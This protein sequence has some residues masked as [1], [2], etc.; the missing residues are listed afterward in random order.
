[1]LVAE[2]ERGMLVLALARLLRRYRSELAPPAIAA[3][4]ALTAAWTHARHSG[5]AIPVAALSVALSATLGAP[6]DRWPLGRYLAR[7]R[8]MERR[9]ERLYAASVVGLAG[10]WLAAAT[11][12]GPGRPPLPTVAALGALVAGVPW[13]THHR[14]RARVQVERVIAAWPTF[15]DA[16]GLPG[17]RLTSAVVD[18]WGWTARLALRRGQTAS[19]AVAHL[20]AIESALAVR[21]GGVRIEPDPRRS[22]RVIVRVIERDPHAEPIPWQPSTATSVRAPVPVGIYE[23]GEPVRVR[24]LHRHTLVG[25]VAGSGKSGLVNAILAGL[26][27]CTDVALWG[28]DLKGGMELQPWA[29][30]LGQLA[31]TAGGA[32][33]LLRAAVSEL[34]ARAALLAARGERL[35][36]PSP[37]A[38]ALLLVIDEYAELPDEAAEFADSIARRGRAVAVN[39]LAATQRPTQ[40]AMGGGAVRSQMDTRICLRVK[41]RRDADIILGQGMLAAGWRADTLNA[42]GKFLISGPEHATPKPARAYLVTDNDV[43]TA[44]ARAAERPTVRYRSAAPSPAAADVSADAAPSPDPDAVLWTALQAAPADGAAIGDLVAITGMSR[45]WVYK[46]LTHYRSTRRAEQTRRGYWRAVPDADT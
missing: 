30:S 7:W 13:W 26:V 43:V 41:E 40:R 19:Q 45:P 27:A 34:E 42:P 3:V 2:D 29:R 33:A 1:M 17:S 38:P 6:P 46:R 28:I 21:P 24:L 25:G 9:A 22:D 15:A 35:W 16:V 18:V 20:G 8:V 32:V 36:R 4:L 14:R 5:W 11:A 44:Q 23:D 31:T 10:A 37:S 12:Y 39:L